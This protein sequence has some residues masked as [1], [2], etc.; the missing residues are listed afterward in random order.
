MDGFPPAP[1][2]VVPD[3]D[4]VPALSESENPWKK[5]G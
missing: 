4:L 3:A 5:H 1:G 2:R